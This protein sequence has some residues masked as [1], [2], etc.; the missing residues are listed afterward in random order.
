MLLSFPAVTLG[1]VW[2]S[3]EGKLLIINSR[4]NQLTSLLP[5]ATCE[6]AI[7]TAWHCCVD[8]SLRSEDTS[9]AA[10]FIWMLIPHCHTKILLLQQAIWRPFSMLM[11]RNGGVQT[12]NLSTLQLYWRTTSWDISQQQRNGEETGEFFFWVCFCLLCFHQL[13]LLQLQHSL[14]YFLGSALGFLLECYSPDSTKIKQNFFREQ[15]AIWILMLHLILS[16]V[17]KEKE[18][19]LCC[20]SIW[21]RRN[22]Q[23]W[24]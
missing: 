3:Q 13:L 17:W 23:A 6:S 12:M 24:D 7:K 16:L 9:Q 10:N 11:N 21:I 2:S 4:A 14:L 5:I 20:K 15:T 19:W 22:L 18:L 8:Q 1:V